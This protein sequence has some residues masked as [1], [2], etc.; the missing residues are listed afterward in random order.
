MNTIKTFFIPKLGHYFQFFNFQFD[1]FFPT[2]KL[3]L[4]FIFDYV[5]LFIIDERDTAMKK[6]FDVVQ[7]R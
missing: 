6:N 2:C 3:L 7:Y 1:F 4:M 5:I